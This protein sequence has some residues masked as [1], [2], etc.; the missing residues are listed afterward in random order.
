MSIQEGLDLKEHGLNVVE[1]N[2]KEFIETMRNELVRY[3]NFVTIVRGNTFNPVEV[4]TD[5]VRQFAE[6]NGLSPRSPNAWGAIFKKAPD[7]FKFVNTG[8]TIHSKFKSN[9]GR[10]IYIFEVKRDQSNQTN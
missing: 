8:R 1:C 10:R 3:F 7:G 9:H 4:T 5:H 6:D 2:N